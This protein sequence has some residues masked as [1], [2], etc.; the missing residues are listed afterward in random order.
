MI[1][2]VLMITYLL[3]SQMILLQTVLFCFLLVDTGQVVG[4]TVTMEK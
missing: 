2:N 4:N 1:T 3:N